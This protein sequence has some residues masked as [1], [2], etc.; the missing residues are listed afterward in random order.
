MIIPICFCNSII[1]DNKS[2]FRSV[3]YIKNIYSILV[4]FLV[5]YGTLV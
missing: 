5:Y 4:Y 3:F 1:A 2:N